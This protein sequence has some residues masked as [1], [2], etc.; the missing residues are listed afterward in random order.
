MNQFCLNGISLKEIRRKNTTCIFSFYPGGID[1]DRLD[2]ANF[3]KQIEDQGIK[4]YYGSNFSHGL[5]ILSSDEARYR[6]AIE[7]GKI[8]TPQNIF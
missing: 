8:V 3:L 2:I 4:Q 5:W 7:T 1:Q 6:Q